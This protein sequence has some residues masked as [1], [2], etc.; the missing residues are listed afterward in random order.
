MIYLDYAANYPTKKLV[1][2]ELYS[3]ELNYIGNA[4]STHSL[5]QKSKQLLNEC[6]DK[7]FKYLNVDKDKYDIIH[8]SSATEANNLAIKGIV[9]SY[10]AFGNKILV[11][12]LEHNSI[13]ATLGYLKEQGYEIEFVKTMPNGKINLEDLKCKLT[14]KTIL[15]CLTLLDSE[16][17]TLQDYLEIT[18]II[19]EFRN[20]HLL[21]DVTQAISKYDFDLNKIEMLSFTPHKFGGLIGT[22]I[23]LKRKSTILTPLIHGGESASVYRSGSIPLGLIASS[24]KAIELMSINKHENVLKMQEIANYFFD[25]IKDIKQIKINSF[26]NLFIFNLSI[27]NHKGFEV[28]NYLSQNE[29]YISQ[30]SACSIKNTPSK[31]VM[32]VYNDKKRA[33][34]SFRISI[35]ELTTKEDIDELVEKLRSFIWKDTKK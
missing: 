17:A 22:G 31:I 16:L 30:K 3:V 35:S 33:L 18:K 20:C 4:N 12:E 21:M 26:T 32:A 10:S 2:D 5:G 7:I 1:L 15:A 27:V 34:E 11:S 23:L 13:N 28:V 24:T 25:K 6:N 8:T 19:S 9:K 14:N 29:I